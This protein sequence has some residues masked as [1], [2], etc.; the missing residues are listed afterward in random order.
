MILSS[1]LFSLIPESA[2]GVRPPK[3]PF[4]QVWPFSGTMEKNI[5]RGNMLFFRSPR[6][7]SRVHPPASAPGVHPPIIRFWRSAVYSLTFLGD[8][9]EE[10]DT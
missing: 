6:T 2:P 4:L 9:G 8:G 3:N 1:M 5:I 10:H 7:R